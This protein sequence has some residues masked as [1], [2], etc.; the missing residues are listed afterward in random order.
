MC[1]GH[2]IFFLLR[3]F[4]LRRSM[5]L[6]A[7]PLLVLG[8]D[9]YMA[10]RI[11]QTCPDRKNLGQNI[12]NGHRHLI[13]DLVGNQILASHQKLDPTAALWQPEIYGTQWLP[14]LASLN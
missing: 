8:C 4:P 7:V 11:G 2:T 1:L 3:V 12:V 6:L 9:L 10:P 14:G 5:Q 13:E